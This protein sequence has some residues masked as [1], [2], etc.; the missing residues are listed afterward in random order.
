MEETMQFIPPSPKF[1]NIQLELLKLY[2]RNVSD[3]ELLKVKDM[4]A[5]Y[6]MN[7]AVDDLNEHIEKQQIS[8]E[9]IESW[10]HEKS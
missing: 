6:F 3:E 10:L 7:K 8:N 5:R 9:T 2:A 4:L 1:S